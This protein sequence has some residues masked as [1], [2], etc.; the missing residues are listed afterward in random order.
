MAVTLS[1]LLSARSHFFHRCNVNVMLYT[2]NKGMHKHI[3]RSIT[4]KKL[5]L[6]QVFLLASTLIKLSVA[7]FSLICRLFSFSSRRFSFSWRRLSRSSLRLSAS[8]RG[9]SAGDRNGIGASVKQI[10]ATFSYHTFSQ[11]QYIFTQFSRLQ[12]NTSSCKSEYKLKQNY[13]TITS[14]VIKVLTCNIYINENVVSK[15]CSNNENREL[16]KTT[17]RLVGSLVEPTDVTS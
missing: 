17:C 9:D 15:H 11:L 10:N 8:S 1:A 5:C 13:T 2:M 14:F 12:F 6:N 3:Y 7:C 4:F 16:S